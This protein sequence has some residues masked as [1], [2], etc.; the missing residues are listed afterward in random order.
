MAPRPY[1]PSAELGAALERGDLTHATWLAK[2]VTDERR[3]PLELELA[4][5][6]LPLVASQTPEAFDLWALRWL[7]RW[8]AETPGA[9]IGWAAD[10][11]CALADMPTEP[12]QSLDSI[13]GTLLAAAKSSPR[14]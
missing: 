14:R 13:S 11:A 8:L 4:L 12:L 9:N 3:R 6:F 7:G 1:R 5:K 10:I 2:E